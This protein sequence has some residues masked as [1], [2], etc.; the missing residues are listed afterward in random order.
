MSKWLSFAVSLLL[1][2]VLFGGENVKA[3]VT[4]PEDVSYRSVQ[5]DRTRYTFEDRAQN[6]LHELIAYDRALRLIYEKSFGWRLDETQELILLSPRQQIANGYAT[7]WPHIKTV[8]YPSGSLMLEEMA[9]SSWLLTLAT[10]ETAHLYQ[11]NAKGDFNR[12]LHFFVGNAPLTLLFGI[13]LFVHPN[14]FAPDFLTEGNSVLNESLFNRGGRLH[15]GEARALV[16]AQVRAGQINPSRLINNELEFPFGDENYLQ[17]GYFF[18]HL[19][20]KYG[21]D[22]ANQLFTTTGNHYI[23]PLR[24]NAAFREHFGSSYP[25]EIREFVRDLERQAQPQKTT[26][27]PVL[28]RG[29]LAGPM[30]HDDKSVWL[31]LS[32]G[33]EPPHLVRYDKKTQT[34]SRNQYDLAM[35]KVFFLNS[36]Q[37]HVAA[38]ARHDFYHIEY[39]LYGPGQTFLPEYR[40]Q[41]V[42]DRRA[43]HT[44]ALDAQGS[45][46]EPQVL[47]DGQFYDV[48]HSSVQI[49]ESGAPF[50]FRQNGEERILYRHRQPIFKFTGFYG[51]P[52]EIGPEGDVYFIANTEFGS[53]LYRHRNNE[54]TRMLESD[55]VVDARRLSDREFLITE[56]SAQGFL[57]KV[58]PVKP[59]AQMPA[60]YSYGIPSQPLSPGKMPDPQEIVSQQRP[61]SAFG[62]MRFSALEARFLISE[63]GLLGSMNLTFADP[64]E[65][66]FLSLQTERTS[67]R[68]EATR[69]SYTYSPHL[70][71]WLAAYEYSAH[72]NVSYEKIGAPTKDRFLR[73]EALLGV[74]LPVRQ[75]RRSR[76]EFFE[77][78]KYRNENPDGLWQEKWGLLSIFSW[79]KSLHPPLALFPWR[80]TTFRF[81]NNLEAALGK[82]TKSVNASI[83]DFQFTHGFPREIYGTG[84]FS[85][86]WA[87]ARDV[88]LRNSAGSQG[89]DIAI[90]RLSDSESFFVKKA[91][92]ARFQ[93]SKVFQTPSYSPR[94]PIGLRRIAPFLAAQSIDL[95]STLRPETP[96]TILEGAYGAD[97]EL[98][99]LH[100][101]PILV[102]Q[103]VGFDNLK[104]ERGHLTTQL[105]FRQDF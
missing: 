7:V 96:A 85:A 33:R 74:G 10:H 87:E 16:F 45:W 97:F 13:P 54:I 21:V 18:A 22:R 88:E 78:L 79:S 69:L 43:G 9:L 58:A 49:D 28:A 95:K 36:D 40:G 19:A 66:N 62:T 93:L 68:E 90:D 37:P 51:K 20:R 14:V 44:A 63:E 35:G 83:A 24:L 100:K 94:I 26:D 61:Y 64:L 46:L 92:R 47:F 104:P 71:D 73:H 52:L 23:N 32:E 27:A 86:A 65:W 2:W 6:F 80:E 56:V 4:L 38:S 8:W 48:A 29:V 25:L 81:K 99:V 67:A 72:E 30:N 12:R 105:H 101:V 102:R 11:L 89:T 50:Y 42:T 3:S 1:F 60:V 39:S 53:S 76:A 15:S 55:T 91:L 84:L 77:L 5:V 17:G 34:L 31:L 57:L 75:K 98:L 41:I 59:V 82:W 70:I 103:M